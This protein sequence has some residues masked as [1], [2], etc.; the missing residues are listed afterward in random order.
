MGVASGRRP[1]GLTLREV[2][3]SSLVRTA[4]PL[5][6]ARREYASR[7]A[8]ERRMAADFQ[9]HWLSNLGWSL[10]EAGRLEEAESV[11]EQAVALAPPTYEMVRGNL[12]EVRRL[13][14]VRGRAA[15][16]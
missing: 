3:F 7:S 12:E 15:K 4:K 10:V 5:V 1:T 9:Y 16:A 8:E 2:P 6:D 11:L 14:R 13:L